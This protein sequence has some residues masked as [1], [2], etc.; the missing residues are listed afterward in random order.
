MPNRLTKNTV[1]LCKVEA[2][3]GVDSVPAGATDAML[4]SNLS[5]T[6][7]KLNTVDRALIRPYLGGSELL[8][9]TRYAECGFDI[10]LVGSGTVATAPAWAAPLRAS[11]FA[12]T[13]TATIR[14][15]YTPISTAMESVTIA[16]FDD[17]V[18]HKFTGARAK[19]K[20][21]K[22]IGERP[23]LSFAFTG[24]YSTPTALANPTAVL[25]GFKIPQ[26]ITDA[27][28]GDLTF[29]ATHNTA[30]APVLT[31]GTVYPSM[32]IE[33]DLG[34]NVSFNALLGGET[35]DLTDRVATGKFTLDL[36]SAQEVAFYAQL[37]GATL[38]SIG[39]AH[40]TVANNKHLLWM[41]SCQL[42]DTRKAEQNGKRLVE[43]DFRAN[44]V[45]GNDEVRLVTSF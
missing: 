37:E 30:T 12:Q 6:P 23:M 11:A 27:N 25:T 44:P 3:Y 26:V 16:W 21:M 4:V 10:E 17:G 29:G 39:L 2:T 40:G 45:L 15:D 43:F 19:L 18:F 34:S 14:A 41:P 1:V 31:A 5:V 9:G 22:K 32:G 7:I 20:V 24:L 33:V 13:L 8:P 38:Q 42:T 36:T 28:T 35:V